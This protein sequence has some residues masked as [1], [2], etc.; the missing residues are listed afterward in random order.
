[1]STIFKTALLVA[2]YLAL[3]TLMFIAAMT[4][5]AWKFFNGQFNILID[6]VRK[7]KTAPTYVVPVDPASD[8]RNIPKPPD[9]HSGLDPESSSD[10]DPVPQSS[11][12][13]SD[14]GSGADLPPLRVSDSGVRRGKRGDSGGVSAGRPRP[15]QPAVG[16]QRPN[17]KT[18]RAVEILCELLADGPIRAAEARDRVISTV[19]CEASVVNNA[20]NMLGIKSKRFGVPG[21]KAG[22]F[23][24]HYPNQEVNPDDF[25]ERHCERS[26]ATSSP[27]TTVEPVLD[28]IGEGDKGGVSDSS[29]KTA[30]PPPNLSRTEKRGRWEVKVK[31]RDRAEIEAVKNEARDKGDISAKQLVG[32]YYHDLRAD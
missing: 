22:I 12:A 13:K 23:I 16:Q 31:P 1:M 3:A 8:V 15:A 18:A 24:W 10:S 11:P 21:S 6:A 14:P 27:H 25:A 2:A 26:E 19:G 32:D 4:A 5:L 9:C 30:N 7:I 20:R 29:E 17:S 28:L